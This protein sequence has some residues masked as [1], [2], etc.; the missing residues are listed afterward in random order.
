M[1]IEINWSHQDIPAWVNWIAWDSGTEATG[2]NQAYGYELRPARGE[3]DALG[4]W[5]AQLEFRGG[6]ET[7]SR[8]LALQVY[9][10][11]GDYNTTPVQRPTAPEP[12]HEHPKTI[13]DEFAMAALTGLLANPSTDETWQQYSE[14]AYEIADEMLK[15]REASH[16]C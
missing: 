16:G 14:W 15:A 4:L 9:D 7:R 10:G 2:V 8:Y 1:S 3:E 6:K 13:R 5:E 12:K 11:F